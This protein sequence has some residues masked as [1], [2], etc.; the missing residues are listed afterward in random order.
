MHTP[1]TE[2]TSPDPPPPDRHSQANTPL[3]RQTPLPHPRRPLQR[4]VRILLYCILFK[5]T[6][7]WGFKSSWFSNVFQPKFFVRYLV[8]DC[9]LSSNNINL[10]VLKVSNSKH[11]ENGR[12]GM[13]PPYKQGS[14]A[15]NPSPCTVGRAPPPPPTVN[16]QV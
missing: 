9:I 4:T 13:Q 7:R 1:W 12:W 15:P 5:L 16:R 8:A 6:S 11:S 3:P 14:I 10:K 2:P